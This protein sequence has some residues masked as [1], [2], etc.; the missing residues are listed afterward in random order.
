MM[1]TMGFDP[2]TT[3]T[4]LQFLVAVY[5]D[6]L[7]KIF[8]NE[9]KRKDAESRGGIGLSYRVEAAKTAS[10]YIHMEM[11]KVSISDDT[12]NFGESLA[13]AARAGNERLRT[14]TMIIETIERISPDVPLPE[15][16]YP[17]MY[18]QNSEKVINEDGSVAGETLPPEGDK[19]YNPDAD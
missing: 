11:P 13:Q 18:G 3:M 9:T 6:D 7:E 16:S 19:E 8:R 5:N 1:R 14:K 10:R 12:G 2:N 17:A 4:P 15:A